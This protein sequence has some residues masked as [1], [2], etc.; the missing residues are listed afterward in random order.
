LFHYNAGVVR[1]AA[2]SSL[3]L[4]NPSITRS[5][6]ELY[7]YPHGRTGF[8]VNSVEE[9]AACA[10]ALLWGEP[11]RRDSIGRAA[12]EEWQT[13][14]TPETYQSRLLEAVQGAARAEA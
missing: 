12:R 4:L 6:S 3:S 14:F 8:L 11:A 13:R 5:I 2:S 7:G 10:L 9:M 1:K